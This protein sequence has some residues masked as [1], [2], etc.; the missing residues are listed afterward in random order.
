MVANKNCT[1]MWQ[2]ILGLGLLAGLSAGAQAELYVYQMPG[3]TRIITDHPLQGKE[4]KLIRK[5]GTTRGVGGMISERRVQSAMFDPESYD[6]L[7][8]RTAAA[9]KVDVALVKAV[10]HAESA[11][12]PNAISPKGASGLMQLMPATAARY[13]V[14]DIFD[15]EQNVQGG[16][17]YLRDLLVMFKNNYH[18]AIAAYNAGENAVIRH[19]GIPPYSET[20]LYVRKVMSYKK[21]YTP[22]PARRAAKAKASVASAPVGRSAEPTLASRGIMIITPPA[23]APVTSASVPVAT[24]VQPMVAQN[25]L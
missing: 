7:I 15:P 13:G 17:R 16:V 22:A 2:I 12:N 14:D 9:N 19:K 10:M 18:L 21:K 4:Y 3:G 25:S 23:P 24:G 5:S 6:R 11:F 1:K 20:R 8:Q